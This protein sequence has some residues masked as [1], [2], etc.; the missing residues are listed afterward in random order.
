MKQYKFVAQIPNGKPISATHVHPFEVVFSVLTR[1]K[2]SEDWKLCF[3]EYMI[4]AMMTSVYYADKNLKRNEFLT[5]VL[6]EPTE[7][8]SQLIAVLTVRMDEI[9]GVTLRPLSIEGTA[10]Q[11]REKIK[12]LFRLLVTHTIIGRREQLYP[13]Y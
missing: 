5:E 4:S 1:N 8:A 7:L 13:T 2:K 11:C 10:D 3:Q 9:N 12:E 6:L